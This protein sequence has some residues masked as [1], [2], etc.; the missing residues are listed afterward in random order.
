[1]MKSIK[2]HNTVAKLRKIMLYNP[3]VDLLKD[4]VY[5]TCG[6]ILPIHSKDIEQ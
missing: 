4:N 6:Y 2:G 1:M 3:N 5:T